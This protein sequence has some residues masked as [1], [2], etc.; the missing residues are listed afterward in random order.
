MKRNRK[1]ELKQ[2]EQAA[3]LGM[4]RRVYDPDSINWTDRI[5]K[6]KQLKKYARRFGGDLIPGRLVSLSLSM[7][8]DMKK[9]C[10]EALEL[11]RELN[12][13]IQLKIDS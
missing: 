4:A 11:I 12:Y 3:A 2:I 10:P 9:Y 5:T 8:E 13:S 6:K 7:F 1:K